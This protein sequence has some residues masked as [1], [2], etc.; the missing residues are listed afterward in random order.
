MSK[1]DT[2]KLYNMSHKADVDVRERKSSFLLIV[3]VVIV[4]ILLYLTG[5]IFAG[6]MDMLGK[7][8]GSVLGL[9]GL[10]IKTIAVIGTCLFVV[11]HFSG[12]KRSEGR[13]DFFNPF[14]GDKDPH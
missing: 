14:G 11:M 8:W 1:N 3:V 6:I 2:K 7:I 10:D 13:R 4:L 12:V 9:V 5:G